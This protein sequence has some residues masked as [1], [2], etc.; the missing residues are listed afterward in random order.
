MKR[1]VL[2]ETEN[3]GSE[4]Y[5]GLGYFGCRDDLHVRNQRIEFLAWATEWNVVSFS[6]M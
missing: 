5:Q 2:K 3:G 4:K 6:E 1:L